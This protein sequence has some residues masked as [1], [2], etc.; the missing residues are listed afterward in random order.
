MYILK[1]TGPV[2]AA[3]MSRVLVYQW[4][5]ALGDYQ[6]TKPIQLHWNTCTP[7]GA[8]GPCQPQVPGVYN[9]G[10]TEYGNFYIA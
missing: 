4:L 2:W 5:Q 1:T 7:G 9:L 6:L 3:S 8:R 10:G